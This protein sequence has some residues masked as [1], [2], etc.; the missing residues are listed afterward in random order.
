[1]PVSF[2]L[3]WQHVA[4]ASSITIV[5]VAAF[6]L[7]AA[8]WDVRTER[9]PNWIT[10]PAAAAGLLFHTVAGAFGHDSW[11]RGGWDG[12]QHALL[13]LAVGFL[14][15]F[16]LWLVGAGGAGDV[17]LMGAVG[18]W[19]GAELTFYTY[20]GSVLAAGLVSIGLL[21]WSFWRPAP[22]VTSKSAP[23]ATGARV[24]NWRAVPYGLPVALATWLVMA[25][26][27]VLVP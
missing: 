22:I 4:L 23:A 1:M 11:L 5:C 13:G 27:L 18:A 7:L 8:I 26:K 16:V 9:L 19:L 3:A 12:L 21:A 2:D 24:R 14:P 6:T 17:K 15:L 25:W 20:V 10:V